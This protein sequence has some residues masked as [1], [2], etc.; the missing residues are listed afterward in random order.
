M[1]KISELKRK[2]KTAFRSNYWRA[3][4]VALVLTICVGS[5]GVAAGGHTYHN[6]KDK[7]TQKR[8]ETAVPIENDLTSMLSDYG[9]D[10]QL[11]ELQPE[12]PQLVQSDNASQ[13]A[14]P[15]VAQDMNSDEHPVTRTVTIGG[16]SLAF[17]LFIIKILL[18][19]PAEV[20]CR[21]FFFHNLNRKASEKEIK[22][23]FD[24]WGRN[25]G[26]MLLRDIF[27][28]LWTCLFIIPG[29]V[30]AY[31]YRMVPYILAEYPE[32]GANEAITRSREMMRG[33]KWRTFLLDLSFIGWWLLSVVT[34]GLVGLFWLSPYYYN[35]DAALYERLKSE[36]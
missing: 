32:C 34:F 23:G 1:W 13:D 30:K 36:A 20:G 15:D 2:G 22:T 27:L 26:S 10:M 25:V 16:M 14:Q 5:V 3:V 7:F 19:N 33:H 35:T 4:L 29:I 24:E 6:T 11:S 18:L 9:I 12:I 8:Q 21:S 28:F 31:A 17:I